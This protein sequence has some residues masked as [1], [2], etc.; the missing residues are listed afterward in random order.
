[1]FNIFGVSHCTKRSPSASISS[2]CRSMPPIRMF[3][4]KLTTLAL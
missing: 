3:R 2:N 1:L 4:R